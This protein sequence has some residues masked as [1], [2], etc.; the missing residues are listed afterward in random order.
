MLKQLVNL[1]LHL[2]LSHLLLYIVLV[3]RVRLQSQA[4]EF[5]RLRREEVFLVKAGDHG[6]VGSRHH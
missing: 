4:S 1:T 5:S 3:V 6:G 2:K